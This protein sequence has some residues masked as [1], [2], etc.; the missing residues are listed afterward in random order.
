M[1]CGISVCTLT[2]LRFD[3]IYSYCV[4]NSATD[5]NPLILFST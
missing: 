1:L 3:Y 2:Y 5:T 4:D